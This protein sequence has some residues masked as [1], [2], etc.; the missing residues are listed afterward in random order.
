MFAGHAALALALKPRLPRLS[1]GLLFAAAFWVDLVWPVLLLLGVERVRV[2]PGA[3]AFTPLDFTHYPWTHSLLLAACWAILFPLVA[4]GGRFRS[5]ATA[6]LA[7]LVFSHWLLDL[8]THRPDLPLVPGLPTKVGLGLWNSVAGTLLVEGALFAAGTA[9]Y[10]RF[11]R[12]RDR[13][14]SL[15]LW[16]LLALILFIWASGPFSPPPP[17]EG[18]IGVVGLFLGLL[19]LWAAW[20]D[21]HRE[22]RTAA[23]AP[24]PEG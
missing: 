10:V 24:R 9:L 18:A 12:P 14:G 16:S 1:L 20:A 23:S 6:G 2:E 8:V 19:P 4:L 5:A 13:T 3:T 15:A 7:F 21:A 17:G 22:P 11:T